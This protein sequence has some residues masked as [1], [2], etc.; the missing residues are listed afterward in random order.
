MKFE[1]LEEK[2]RL[3]SVLIHEFTLFV[4]HAQEMGFALC[5]S[6]FVIAF[7]C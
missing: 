4:K 5:F 2:A 7:C 1:H 6:S 3:G